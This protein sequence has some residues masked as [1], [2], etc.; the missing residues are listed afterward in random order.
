MIVAIFVLSIMAETLARYI[1]FS[2]E[3][4]LAAMH[5]VTKQEESEIN[6][7]LQ[8]VTNRVAAQQGLPDEMVVTV[9][10]VD[11]E[12][13]N[14]FATLGGHIFLFRGLLEKLPHENALAMLIAHE[15]AHIKHRHPIR[16]LGRAVVMGVAISMINGAVGNDVMGQVLGEAGLMTALT[17]SREQESEADREAMATVKKLYGHTHGASDL[18][19]ALIQGETENDEPYEIFSTHPLISERIK[20]SSDD[21]NGQLVALP[22]MFKAWLTVPHAD[23]AE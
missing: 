23:V 8:G 12:T 1:P 7:Y 14:A 2:A 5:Q 10:Y 21:A 20:E 11:N 3:R 19:I 15:V 13:V 18:F 4:D 6:R 17:F 9:H 22:A 16:G